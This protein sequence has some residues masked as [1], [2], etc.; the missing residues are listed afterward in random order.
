M[1]PRRL[2]LAVGSVSAEDFRREGVLMREHLSRDLGLTPKTD[3]LDVGCGVGRV[4]IPLIGFLEGRYEGFD[5]T[6]RAIRWC[7]RNITSQAPNFRFQLADV[8]SR[9]YN[10]KGHWKANQY[11]FPFDDASFDIVV[12]TSVL[13]HLLPDAAA[14]YVCETARVLRPAGMVL[15]TYLL[16]NDETRALATRG[17]LPFAF[18]VQNAR[19]WAVRERDPEAVVAYPQ[20]DVIALFESLGFEP[21]VHPGKWAGRAEGMTWQDAVVARFAA[22]DAPQRVP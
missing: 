4:A 8:Q 22:I 13:T 14:N 20:A 7:Q 11:R 9:H 17:A 1:P 21:T 19:F 16:I 10:P 3:I 6:P 15:A 2:M 12:H 18:R 5:V